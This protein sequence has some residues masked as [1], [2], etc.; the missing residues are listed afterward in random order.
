MDTSADLTLVD[1]QIVSFAQ[2][3]DDAAAKK[4]RGA[5]ISSITAAEFLLMQGVSGGRP[6]YY[7]LDP[8]RF[9]HLRMGVLY[10]VNDHWGNK[11]WAAGNHHRTDQL[12]LEFGKDY[13][14]YI[15]Y[16]NLAIAEILNQR[17][18]ELFRLSISHLEKGKQ[19]YRRKRFD[20]LLQQELECHPVTKPIA[21]L[22]VELFGAFVSAHSPKSNIRNTLNDMLILATARSNGL[23]LLTEDKLLN[24]FGA[25]YCGVKASIEG[26]W[27]RVRFREAKPAAKTP[28]RESKGYINRGWEV[29]VRRDS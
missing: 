3:G 11:K 5:G 29:K 6:D 14:R 19:K 1:T 2:K 12:I 25:E 21:Q 4:V 27:L 24:Q 9:R 16:G 7:V 23:D 13:P 22:A 28:M 8:Q 18:T 15:E 10:A 20:Y 26:G 17:M